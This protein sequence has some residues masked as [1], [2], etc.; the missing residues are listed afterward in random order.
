MELT[1]CQRYAVSLQ[2]IG[3]DRRRPSHLRSL[4]RQYIR[5]T[6]KVVPSTSNREAV[7]NYTI[8]VIRSTAVYYPRVESRGYIHAKPPVHGVLVGVGYN[9]GMWPLQSR[10][11]AKRSRVSER[12]KTATHN[13]Y[14]HTGHH[15]PAYERFYC[16]HG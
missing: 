8:R 13:C 6:E 4:W 7:G 12:A 9:D 10:L 5:I 14:R 1:T 2:I 15:I 11:C 16:P 3:T